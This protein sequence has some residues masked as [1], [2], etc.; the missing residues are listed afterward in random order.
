MIRNDSVFQNKQHK[1][2]RG[3]MLGNVGVKYLQILT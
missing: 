2:M 1:R 3:K